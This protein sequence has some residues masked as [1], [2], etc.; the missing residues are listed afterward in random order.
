MPNRGAL[1]L[2]LAAIAAAICAIRVL[3]ADRFPDDSD[4]PTFR[5][6]RDQRRIQELDTAA[7]PV[8]LSLLLYWRAVFL[9]HNGHAAIPDLMRFVVDPAQY[10]LRVTEEVNFSQDTAYQIITRTVSP[11]VEMRNFLVPIMRSRKGRVVDGLRVTID[12]K[13]ASTLSRP[14]TQGAMSYVLETLFKGAYGPEPGELHE[15]SALL[16]K[17]LMACLSWTPLSSDELADM[18]NH[19]G[20]LPVSDRI[21]PEARVFRKGFHDLARYLAE[22]YF[23][24][25]VVPQCMPEDRLKVTV[26]RVTPRRQRLD[27]FSNRLRTS[28][29]LSI[30]NYLVDLPHATEAASYHFTTDCPEGTYFFNVFARPIVQPAW[31]E[32]VARSDLASELPLVTL[33]ANNRPVTPRV[34]VNEAEG[35][36]TAHVYGRHLGGRLHEVGR[37]REE[38]ESRLVVRFFAEY[39]ERPPGLLSTVLPVSLYL[40]LLVWG[41]GHFHNLVFPVQAVA[42]GGLA[43][44][45]ASKGSTSG[46]ATEVANSTW[47]AIVLSIPALV[48]GWILARTTHE[49]LQRTSLSTLGI[50]AWLVCNGGAAV[51]IAA[52]KISEPGVSSLNLGNGFTLTHL[53][54]VL[55][56]LSTGT[57]FVLAV[58]LW[59]SRTSRYWQRIR[60]LHY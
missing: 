11:D 8:T 9:R 16:A 3:S 38:L 2:A 12:G 14:E 6:R 18:D 49:A 25:V 24:I 46:S 58:I 37:E 20:S 55:I 53:A 15:Y 60:L 51:G 32:A 29:G 39:R 5:T 48:S 1:T 47:P 26:E 56:M 33:V 17:I 19:L 23:I 57:Q 44:I 50:T 54:W 52:L 59:I 30:R 22:S 28:L 41:I 27:G 21:S 43:A 7:E 31:S 13:P 34:H 45:H 4:M 42:Q 40:V 10:V 36:N 35:R